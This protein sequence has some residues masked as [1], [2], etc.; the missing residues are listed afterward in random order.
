[1]PP[2]GQTP[3]AHGGPSQPPKPPAHPV[4]QTGG[5]GAP[6]APKATSAWVTLSGVFGTKLPTA[7]RQAHIFHIRALRSIR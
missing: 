4:G 2:L 5:K 7:L 3:G 1:M 6:I